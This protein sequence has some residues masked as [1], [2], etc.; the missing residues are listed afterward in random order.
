MARK[1]SFPE[2]TPV[3]GKQE[4]EERKAAPEPK[5]EG[6]ETVAAVKAARA[7]ESGAGRNRGLVTGAAI[8]IGSAALVAALLYA[9]NARKSGKNEPPRD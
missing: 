3:G 1:P 7:A 2:D 9:R 8:G 6:G 4:A 5:E